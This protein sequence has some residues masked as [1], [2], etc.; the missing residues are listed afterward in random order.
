MG[1]VL[2]KSDSVFPRLLNLVKL[3]MGG[4]QGGGQQYVAWVHE[5]DAAGVTEWLADNATLQGVFNCTAPNPV[6]NEELMHT[7]RKAYKMPFG[8]PAPEWLLKVGSIVI[9]TEPEL[10]LKSRWVLPTRLLESGF[11]F[12]YETVDRAVR[13]ILK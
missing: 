3:G 13:D 11:L 4:K 10:I 5:L 2:G 9:G 8:L 12:K 1:I 7:I 6:K